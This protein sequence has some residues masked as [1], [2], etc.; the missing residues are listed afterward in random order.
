MSTSTV[1]YTLKVL[2]S[3]IEITFH[4]PIVEGT[5]AEIDELGDTVERELDSRKNPDC[6]MDLSELTYMGSSVV[7][8]LVR[9]W[10]EVKANQGKMV[11]ATNHP[12]V[13]EIITL[14]GLD[15]IWTIQPNLNAA[16]KSIG[17]PL[18]DQ[19][20][21]GSNSNSF[22]RNKIFLLIVALA[23]IGIG[24]GYLLNQT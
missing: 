24:I 2:K 8:L 7:A 11:I 5:W 17:A 13:K 4:P 22:S 6:V 12:L 1:P 20:I 10:K 16:R 18:V 9:I 23:A 21:G 19:E 3:H 14:A 15:K